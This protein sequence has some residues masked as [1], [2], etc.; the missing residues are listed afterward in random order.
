M[1]YLEARVT[2]RVLNFFIENQSA[3]PNYVEINSRIKEV[4]GLNNFFDTQAEASTLLAEIRINQFIE[5]NQI[6][7]FL[8]LGIILLHSIRWLFRVCTSPLTSPSF[9][10]LIKNQ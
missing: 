10:L 4:S 6:F 1:T 9:Q 3:M 8:E 5:I 2:D 7:Q